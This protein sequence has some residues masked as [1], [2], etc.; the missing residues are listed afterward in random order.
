LTV[1]KANNEET[2]HAAVYDYNLNVAAVDLKDQMF[3]LY[4]LQ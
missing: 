1:N 4:L 3:Q 2:K